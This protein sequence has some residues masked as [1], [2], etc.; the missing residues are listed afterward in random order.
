M[1]TIGKLMLCLFAISFLFISYT[2]S[3][4]IT[5]S[6]AQETFGISSSQDENLT[7]QKIFF[8][9]FEHSC[10]DQRPQSF[11]SGH[12]SNAYARQYY[13]HAVFNK[14]DCIHKKFHLFL[15]SVPL[16]KIKQLTE[17]H[18]PTTLPS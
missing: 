3:C 18:F 5:S 1:K 13:Q 17:H 2:N 10:I 7:Q 11:H 15:S 14:I 12:S 6:N 9:E 16:L 8:E 4:F